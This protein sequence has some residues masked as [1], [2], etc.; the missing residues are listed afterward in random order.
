MECIKV[1]T[2]DSK[3]EDLEGF[4]TDYVKI[5]YYDLPSNFSGTYKTYN[6]T[7]FCTILEGEKEVT[8]GNQKFKYNSNNYLLLPANTNV[9]MD[10]ENHTRALVFELNDDLIDRVSN[11][12]EIEEDTLQ[13][14]KNNPTYFLG[15]NK[16]DICSDIC[17][18]YEE[19]R[20]NKKNKEFLIDL[21]AQQLVFNLMQD[22]AARYVLKADDGN[23]INIAIKY[24]NENIHEQINLGDLSKQLYMS[25]PNFTYL[26][27]KSTGLTPGEYIKDK[28]L[29]LS[30]AYLKNHSVTD[31]AYDLGYMN[32]SYFI[33][34]FKDKYNLTP[35]QYQLTQYNN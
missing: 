9:N 17:S 24:I 10:I 8:L 1:S 15:D 32:L 5:L 28:K 23:P 34:I 20:I 4:E 26:F 12:I 35:K 18:I 7:R 33:K 25:G 6:Y 21:Y 13:K 2:F 27:K 14:I 29:E 3:I 16:L 22:K 11:N 30:A 19:S 31:V